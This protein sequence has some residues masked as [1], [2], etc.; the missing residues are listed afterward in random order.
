L[1]QK[2]KIVPHVY[3]D[4][5]H[6]VERAA[7]NS[8]TGKNKIFFCLPNEKKKQSTKIQKHKGLLVV[9]DI[10][11]AN[12]DAIDQALAWTLAKKSVTLRFVSFCG[13]NF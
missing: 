9:L 7:R 12:A 10:L 6:I 5:F 8:A 11:G 4:K 2:N 13:L 3:E 1:K